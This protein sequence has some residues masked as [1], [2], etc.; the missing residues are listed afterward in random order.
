[1][2]FDLALFRMGFFGA[3]HEWGKRVNSPTLP[4]PPKICHTCLNDENWHS[5]TL[6]KEDPKIY[7]SLDAPPVFC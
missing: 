1:M 3:F 5:Y 2:G 6:P 7:E 4:P